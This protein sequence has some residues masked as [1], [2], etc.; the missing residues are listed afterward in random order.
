MKN[1]FFRKISI[2]GLSISTLSMISFPFMAKAQTVGGIAS[3]L[4]GSLAGC[5]ISSLI[6]GLGIGNI[7]GG[8]GGTPG[9]SGGE[10]GGGMG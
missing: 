3:G 7:L 4:G 6:G 2:L 9:G 8:G 10:A 1:N 5:A